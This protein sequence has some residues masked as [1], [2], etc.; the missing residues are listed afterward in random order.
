MGVLDDL[1]FFVNLIKDGF[2]KAYEITVDVI[3]KLFDFISLLF[4]AFPFDDSKKTIM[5]GIILFISVIG[6]TMAFSTTSWFTGGGVSDTGRVIDFS[7][8]IQSIGDGSVNAESGVN[9]SVMGSTT[10]LVPSPP[11]GG[12][13]CRNDDN[14]RGIDIQLPGEK[15]YTVLGDTLCCENDT[16]SD[17]SCGGYCLSYDRLTHDACKHPA[18]CSI[19]RDF[20]MDDDPNRCDT[21]PE[22]TRDY[23]CQT[24]PNNGIKDGTMRCCMYGPCSG[25]CTKQNSSDSCYDIKECD[26]E[27]LPVVI[28]NG[29][30]D[31]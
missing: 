23:W 27:L 8:D 25:Y 9:G 17:Y 13:M 2:S 5:L 3:G 19:P 29:I 30:G 20:V 4:T 10:T 21:K 1:G 14:C 22:N 7:V 24:R 31:E 18:A 6:L 12:H 16:Y 28:W 15:D 11:L 26:E